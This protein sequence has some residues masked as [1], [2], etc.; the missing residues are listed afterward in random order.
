ML[1]VNHETRFDPEAAADWVL[2][3]IGR[4]QLVTI[5]PGTKRTSAMELNPSTAGE[6]TMWIEKHNTRG[7]NIYFGL[8]PPRAGLNS[9]ASKAN[10]ESLRGIGAD[11]DMKDGRTS[12]DI[13]R[14]IK[15][16]TPPPSHI[17]FSGGG[18]QPIWLFNELLPVSPDNIKRVEALGKSVADT[19]NGD[20]VQNIDRLYR[21][22]FTQNHP[23]AKKLRE[24]RGVCV[25]GL[26]CLGGD[27]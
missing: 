15:T 24:G 9:K 10:I 12:D 22:P 3:N 6:A 19:L 20:A 21:L 2:T 5:H 27:Q 7:Y 17:I 25:S 1:N 8:N 11:V 26:L 18:Y 4:T 16:V 13:I 14:A 23:N